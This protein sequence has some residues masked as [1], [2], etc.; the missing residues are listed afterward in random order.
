M[1]KMG[2]VAFMQRLPEYLTPE[3]WM[4]QIF[5]AQAARDGGV[6]RRQ[7]MDVE[8]L[9]GREA[10]E[11]ELKRRGYSAVENAGQYVIFCNHE[12]LRLIR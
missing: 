5:S 12:G 4:R 11:R 2:Q 10:L 8:R 3:K 6:V 7:A 1:T 9:V